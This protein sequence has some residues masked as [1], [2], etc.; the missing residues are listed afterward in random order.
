MTGMT[1][2]EKLPVSLTTFAADGVTPEPINGPMVWLSS[3]E[4]IMTAAPSADGLSG[5][6]VSVGPGIA[7]FTWSADA[8]MAGGG[9]HTITLVSEDVTVT[10]VVVEAAVI[11]GAF[12]APVAK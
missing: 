12:G 11:K 9:V 4:A 1:T 8:D 5:F 10:A 3:D 6:A 2:A 7:H